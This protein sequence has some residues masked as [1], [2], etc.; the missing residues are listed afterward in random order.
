VSGNYDLTS[1]LFPLRTDGTCT[2][3]SWL[4]LQN[5]VCSVPSAAQPGGRLRGQSY[6]PY[7]LK[8]F[9]LCTYI[10]VYI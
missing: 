5:H 6:F 10:Y 1:I 2:E 9:K 7:F 3:L 8:C 4:L